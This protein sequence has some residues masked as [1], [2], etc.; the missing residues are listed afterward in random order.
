L[1]KKLQQKLQDVKSN[2][3]SLNKKLADTLQKNSTRLSIQYSKYLTDLKDKTISR[4]QAKEKRIKDKDIIGY[5]Y[6]DSFRNIKRMEHFEKSLGEIILD[7]LTNFNNF[8]S[9]KL[10][11]YKYS[12]HQFLL[13]NEEK[14]CNNNIY[15]KLTKKQVEKLYHQLRSKNLISLIN[16]KYP[17]NLEILMSENFMG[18]CVVLS[19]TAMNQINSTKIDKLNDNSFT[20]FFNNIREDKDHIINNLIFNNCELKNIELAKIPFEFQ[21]LKFTNSKIFASI[22]NNMN[23][24]NLIKFNLDNV[25]IDTYNFEKILGNLLK[26]ENRNLKEISAKNNY[27]SR[28]LINDELYWNSNILPSLEI[29]NLANNNIYNVDKRIFIIMPN[30]KILDLSNNCL[31]HQNN[32]KELIKNCK[33]IVLLLKNIAISKNTFYN[34]YIDYYQK[35]LTKNNYNEIPLDYINF[36]SLF[37]KRTNQNILKWDFSLTKK[38][39]NISELNLSSCSLDNKSVSNVLTNCLS[40][41]NSVAK[42]NLSYNEINEEIF[43]ILIEDKV[44][45]ILHKLKELDLSYNLIKFHGDDG[46][47]KKNQFVIFLNKYSK[48]EILNLKS[49]PFEESINTYIK[50]EIKL[51]F[52]KEKK[53]KHKLL[54]EVHYK[55]IKSIVEN[56]CLDINEDFLIIINDLITL[57]YTSQKRMKPL[58]PL[59]EQHLLIDNLKPEEKR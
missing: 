25:Q 57:K 48:I 58:I 6:Y 9:I 14:L 10:P 47:P 26:C 7:S 42:L 29:F 4:V 15:S 19:S 28:I 27:I 22:F 3:S 40:M 12:C 56:N 35:F 30:I 51:H 43:N 11:Y 8:I 44:K 24:G 18:D 32:C 23:F 39:E 2:L 41:K 16:G 36:D 53:Q 59:L 33:G 45:T 54:D 5:F 46:D 50:D 34:Y 21:N 38:I 55:Q 31:L 17:V 37:Y 13:N 20:F 1:K 49:T 52:A